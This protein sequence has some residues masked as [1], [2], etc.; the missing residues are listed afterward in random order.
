[1]LQVTKR[2]E[3]DAGH[4]LLNHAGKC[5][6]VHGHRYAFEV[7]FELVK[8][9]VLDASGILIDFGTIKDTLGQW[10]ND[11]LDHAFIVQEGDVLRPVIL[12]LKLKVYAMP[13]APTAENLAK[14]VFDRAQLCLGK[15]DKVVKVVR[16]RCYETPTSYADYGR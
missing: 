2:L 7:T 5:K 10:L 11:T 12:G 4:R 8:S 3:I 6:N 14:H 1:M 16:V 13:D 15:F 9:A